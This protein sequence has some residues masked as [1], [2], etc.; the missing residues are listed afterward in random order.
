MTVRELN[1]DQKTELKTFMYGDIYN[2]YPSYDI[3]ANIDEHISDER[4]FEHYDG[5]DFTCDD[6][7]CS[8]G[9]YEE[10]EA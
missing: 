8:A 1:E 10:E 2:E 9:Q 3:L 6:F 5:V 4:L 7:F